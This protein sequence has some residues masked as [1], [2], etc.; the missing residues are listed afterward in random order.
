MNQSVENPVIGH[1][2]DTPIYAWMYAGGVKMQFRRIAC[3]DDTG[4]VPMSQLKDNECVVSPGLIYG[5]LEW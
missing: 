5:E 2:R 1:Y 4:S 3:E